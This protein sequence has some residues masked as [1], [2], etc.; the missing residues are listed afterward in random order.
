ML[1]GSTSPIWKEFQYLQ[2]SSKIMLCVSIDGETGPCPKCFSLV[3]HL[4]PSLINNCLNLPYGRSWRLNEDCFLWSMKLGHRKALCPGPPQGPARY[5]YY[6]L[7][8]SDQET[9]AQT[10]KLSGS[11]SRQVVWLQTQTPSYY[12]TLQSIKRAFLYI[13]THQYT[14][15]QKT[16][17]TFPSHVL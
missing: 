14:E 17:K 6:H 10:S 11:I 3:S 1:V 7:Q 15:L 12:T 8:F 2:N 13:Y 9:K 16:K 5:H 4:C